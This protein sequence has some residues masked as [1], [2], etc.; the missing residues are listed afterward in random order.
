MKTLTLFLSVTTLFTACSQEPVVPP[1]TNLA[2]SEKSAKIIAADN[3]FGFELLNKVVVAAESQQNLMISPMSVSLALGMLYNGAE[4]DTRQQMQDMLHKSGLSPD[5]VNQSYKELV[6]GLESH[7]PK[8]EL[9]IANAIFYRNDL[10]VKSDFISTNQNYYS[11]EV[12]GLDFSKPEQAL[13]TVNGWVNAKTKG[14]ID[15]IISR[16]DPND[17][18]YLLNAIYF[19]GQWTYQFDKALTVNRPFTKSDQSVIQVPTMNIENDFKAFSTADF[20]L[21]EMPYG[22][23][24]FSMLIFLPEPGK[25]AD[26]VVGQLSA[27][28]VND[29]ISKLSVSKKQVYLPKFEFRF[30]KSLV[31]VLKTLGMTD[32]F[33][34]RKADLSGIS[35][36]AQLVVTEVMHKTYI[37]VDEEGTEAAA[38][39]GITVGYTSVGPQSNIFRVDHPFVFAIREKDTGAILFVGKVVDPAQS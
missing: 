34:D 8:V 16:V 23:E 25:T 30:D 5:E 22:G 26:D 38:V 19:K 17:V 14:K 2:P 24:K 37:K 31:E 9:S 20:Q 13:Q 4:G 33:D 3:R 6:S 32:A 11:A 12:S 27:D 10:S 36:A 15:K 29:W 35:D 39:T 18:M 1:V 21:L 7:D 28:H